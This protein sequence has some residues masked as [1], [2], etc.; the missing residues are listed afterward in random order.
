MK[1]TYVFALSLIC[2]TRHSFETSIAIWTY[3][4]TLSIIKIPMNSVNEC[5]GINILRFRFRFFLLWES[6][7]NPAIAEVTPHVGMLVTV[8]HIL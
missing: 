8:V 5:M 6:F 3:N 1:Q 2:G 4:C 7:Y